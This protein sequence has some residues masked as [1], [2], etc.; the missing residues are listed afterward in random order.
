MPTMRSPGTAPVSGAIRIGRFAVNAP[1]GDRRMVLAALARFLLQLQRRRNAALLSSTFYPI[2]LSTSVAAISPRPTEA[3]TSSAFF[4]PNLGTAAGHFLFLE[5]PPHARQHA[6]QYLAAKPCI[7]LPDSI[8]GGTPDCRPALPVTANPSHAAGG[9]CALE[10][11][12]STSSP[13]SSS[14]MSEAWRPLMR[15]PTQSRQVWCGR[16]RRNRW[17]LRPWAAR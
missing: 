9:T 14:L 1:D 15:Q 2:A 7:L 16:H 17:A 11:I 10:R 12:M 3:R 5:C 8:A 13:F 4:M 6:R